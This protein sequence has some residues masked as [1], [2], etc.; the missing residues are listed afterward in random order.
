MP[1]PR[2]YVATKCRPVDMPGRPS[3]RN[4]DHDA[5]AEGNDGEVVPRSKGNNDLR[6]ALVGTSPVSS[7]LR[8]QCT[9]V[10]SRLKNTTLFENAVA[11]CVELPYRKA[12]ESRSPGLPF[13][14]PWVTEFKV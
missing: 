5:R 6:K 9:W 4:M 8:T 1:P 10:G 3:F 13:R 2:L 12:V 7:T 11:F 14:L